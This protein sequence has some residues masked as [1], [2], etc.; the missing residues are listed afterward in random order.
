[1]QFSASQLYAIGVAKNKTMI[2]RN[3]IIISFHTAHLGSLNAMAK[4]VTSILASMSRCPDGCSFKI[5][6]FLRL[7]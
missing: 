2:K 6:G 3:Y 5:C 1:V 7:D 4:C